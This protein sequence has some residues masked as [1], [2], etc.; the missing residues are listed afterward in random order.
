MSFRKGSDVTRFAFYKAHPGCSVEYGWEVGKRAFTA[1]G[2]ETFTVIHD[3][4]WRLGRGGRG[5]EKR[6]IL[7]FIFKRKL[8]EVKYLCSFSKVTEMLSSRK[9]PLN[10]WSKAPLQCW[11]LQGDPLAPWISLGIPFTKTTS[12][13][14]L[15]D[16]SFRR[17]LLKTS[18]WKK[19]GWVAAPAAA[20]MGRAA[21]VARRKPSDLFEM[22][23]WN[24]AG[25]HGSGE[26]LSGCVCV[27]VCPTCKD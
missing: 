21:P 27:C 11:L 20:S 12:V 8:I 13:D 1:V 25:V 3:R 18:S 15:K 10:R 4:C 17:L 7:R 26:R 16:M 19:C 23:Y 6:L 9:S 2:V 14:S 5:G 22:Q 24:I